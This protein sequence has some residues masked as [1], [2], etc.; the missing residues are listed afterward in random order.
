VGTTN[1]KAELI[2][3]IWGVAIRYEAGSW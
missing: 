3:K 1:K 2:A